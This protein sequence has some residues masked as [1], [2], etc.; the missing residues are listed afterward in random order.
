MGNGGSTLQLVFSNAFPKAGI[1]SPQFPKPLLQT[2]N[3]S[4]F[5]SCMVSI[6]K[7]MLLPAGD[8]C[9]HRAGSKKTSAT[10]DDTSIMSRFP[11][12]AK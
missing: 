1:F 5:N 3:A 12:P 10:Q 4:G 11:V 7:H 8:M 6:D 9:R 2:P